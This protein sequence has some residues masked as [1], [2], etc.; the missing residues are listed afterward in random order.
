MNTTLF[1]DL[2]SYELRVGGTNVS[3]SC[4]TRNSYSQPVTTPMHPPVD[5]YNI[6]SEL[7]EDEKRIVKIWT[8]YLTNEVVPMINPWWEKGE[9]PKEILPRIG[10]IFEA[11]A[12][13]G[14]GGFMVDV[15]NPIRSV[16]A[17]GC[18]CSCKYQIPCGVAFR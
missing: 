1:F 12:S 15:F 6:F 17:V 10:Q 4:Q 2:L 7:T 5:F 3:M 18:H 11:T 8:D 9:F 13:D 14:N 16:H